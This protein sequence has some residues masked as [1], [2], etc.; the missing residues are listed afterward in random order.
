MSALK[1]VPQ[2]IIVL[3][4]RIDIA[5]FL[6][7]YIKHLRT[8]GLEIPKVR[9][10]NLQELENLPQYLED[11]EQ[12]AVPA[13]IG[14]VLIFADA[15]KKRLDTQYFIT[16]ALKRSFLQNLEYD[17][18]LFP[19]KSAKGNW[20]PGFLEDLLLP[21]LSQES[22]EKCEFYNLH[23]VTHEFLFSVQNCRGKG[24]R[25]VNSS[26]NF[27]YSYLSGTEKFVGLRLGEAAAKGAFD[28]ENEVFNDLREFLSRLEK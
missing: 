15:T 2:T 13:N 9:I 28:L 6:D 5:A 14:K 19:R 4:E 18:Y 1:A 23:S 22:S 3:C 10:I 17:F 21:A 8:Q 24:N 12:F 16:A 27:L 25:F 7:V 26:R 11:L 20:A